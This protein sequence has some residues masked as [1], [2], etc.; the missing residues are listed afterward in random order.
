MKV[1][2]I[3]TNIEDGVI[4]QSLTIGNEYEVIGI[5]ADYYRI[6]DDKNE[7]ILF[8]PSCFEI[9]D[10]TEPSFWIS[11]NG[12]DGERYCYPETWSSAGFFEDFF[13]D[14]PGVQEKFWQEYRQLY[15]QENL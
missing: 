9:V 2:L 10:D 7:P 3:N 8:D 1:K 13:D 15:E 12:K 4:I 5:E 14:I 11:E 6:I